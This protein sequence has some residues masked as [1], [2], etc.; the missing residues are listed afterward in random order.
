MMRRRGRRP[1]A[2]AS[3][4]RTRDPAARQE[5]HGVP[6]RSA[7][8][9]RAARTRRLHGV[10]RRVHRRRGR[11]AAERDRRGVRVGAARAGARRQGRVPLRDAQSQRGVPARA[12]A[13]ADPRGD[14]AAARRRLPRDRQHRVAKPAGV[15]RRILALRRR[16]ARSPRRGRALGRP[17]PVPGV[18]DRRAHPVAGLHARRRA[19]RRRAREVIARAGSRRSIA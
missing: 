17:H 7:R 6:G 2:H 3:S 9:Q 11:R 5:P 15:P 19:D 14:R 13:P 4:V 10:A 12:R 16:P 8:G 1:R 18:R